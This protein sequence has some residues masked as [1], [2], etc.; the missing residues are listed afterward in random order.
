MDPP[1]LAF[2]GIRSCELK[3]IDVLDR[4]FLK[5][6]FSNPWYRQARE[7]LITIA[8]NCTRPSSNCFC[9]TTHSGPKAKAGFDLSV[10]EILDE[11]EPRYYV[12]L[13]SERMAV[14][15]ARLK[16]KKADGKIQTKAKELLDASADQMKLRFQPQDA[17]QTLK[18]NLEHPQWERIAEKCL[19]CANC[20]MV[21][22]TCFCT[23]V[24]D[25]TDITG[26]NTE[27]WARWD[28]CFNGDFS[29]IHGG[30]IR[31]TTKSRYR[32]WLTHK[33]SSWYDQ[34]GTF[35]CVGCGRC[36]TWCPVGIDL[37]K[38]FATIKTG[39]V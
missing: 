24:E 20:T 7:D 11:K 14:I 30:K 10:T 16:F 22:P 1:K 9:T 4:I 31:N 25:M 26:E 29:Y 19:S 17:A 3:A 33:F 15:V 37:T 23:T 18:N 12:E 6:D 2:W 8:V 38:E 32:Q 13:G 39:E 5:G 34:Y 21:C 36:I 27:R 35:G 28:S